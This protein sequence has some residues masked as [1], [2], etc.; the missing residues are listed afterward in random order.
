M[1]YFSGT[2]T[3][4]SV[5]TTALIAG[6]TG[7]S[8]PAAYR[9]WRRRDIFLPRAINAS[10]NVVNSSLLNANQ[11][12]TYNLVNTGILPNTA[13]NAGADCSIMVTVDSES[14]IKTI[15]ARSTGT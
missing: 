7:E 11:L 15:S 1:Q 10:G 5:P 9:I 8:V 6:N 14:R 12:L 3:T 2:P 13:P 4:L